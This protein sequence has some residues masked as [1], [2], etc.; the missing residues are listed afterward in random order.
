MANEYNYDKDN[1]QKEFYSRVYRVNKPKKDSILIYIVLFILTFISTTFAGVF[2]AGK[3]ALQLNNFRYGLTYSAL[4]MLVITAHEFGHYFA[5]RIHKVNT[6]LPYYIPAPFIFFLFGTMGAVIKLKEMFF[7][8]KALFDIAVAGPIAGWVVSMII[9]VIGFLTLPP[10]D[11]L[12]SIHPQYGSEGIPLD[13]EGLTFGYNITFWAMES[14]LVPSGSFMPPMNEVYHYPLLCVGWF[15]LLITSLNM[16]PVGQLDGG[17]ISYTMFPFKIHKAL[18]YLTF[19]ILLVLGVPGLIDYLAFEFDWGFRIGFG[20]LTWLVWAILIKF[21]V[22]V[23]HPPTVPEND[24]PLGTGRMLIGWFT[25]F[26]FVTSFTP[27]LAFI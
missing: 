1:E 6:T 7:S 8:R 25:Y 26:I 23:E 15:G 21:L 20:S 14:L 18:A 4:V 3:D 2:L 12:Y 17:H 22:R 9:L 27:M 5:A 10:I 16:M 24:P 19:Y 11:Y 13:G